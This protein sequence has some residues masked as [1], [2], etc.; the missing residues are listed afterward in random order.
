PTGVQ[1]HPNFNTK[2]CMN[3]AGNRRQNGTPVQ[4]FDCNG[5]PAQRWNIFRGTTRVQLTGTNF[6]LDAGSPNQFRN[7]DKLKIFRCI[8]SIQAQ[9]WDYTNQNQIRLKATES[10]RNPQCVDLP[11]GQSFN[12]NQL[13]TFQCSN[14]NP[15]QIWTTTP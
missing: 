8:D 11:R 3:V 1:I 13:Q 5:S 2:K 9:I 4:I 7:G 12:G 10:R 14:R 15:N 6:C